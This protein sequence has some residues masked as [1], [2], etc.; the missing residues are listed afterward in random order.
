MAKPGQTVELARLFEETVAL[1]HR[2]SADASMI[3]RFGAMSGPRRTVLIALAQTG[4]QTVA[5]LARAR[6]QSRQ[7][8]QPL[9][10]ELIA[11][12][13]IAAHSNPMHT[14]SPLMALTSRGQKTVKQI[15]ETEAALRA[16]LKLTSSPGNMARAAAVLRDVRLALEQQLPDVVRG[17]RAR[18]T[19]R[20]RGTRM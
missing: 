11:D 19:K 2:L 3:H 8:F 4:S 10:N 17:L 18:P 12:G 7:R 15:L 6:A 16:R 20:S 13:L 5:H 14:R 1:Y 9:V